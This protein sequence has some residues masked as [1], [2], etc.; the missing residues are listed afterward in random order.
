MEEK[1]MR[2]EKEPW[3]TKV[4]FNTVAALFL[5]VFSVVA[6]LLI[7]Y[8]IEKPRMLFGRS[9]MNLEPSL[10]PRLSIAGLFFLSL[11][12]LTHSFQIAEKNL[13]KEMGKAGVIRVGVTFLV[14]LGYALLFEPLG[15][16]LS[17]ALMVLILTIYFGNRN[18]L[19]I[20][21]VTAAA[22]LIV[23]Y[24]FTKTLQVSLPEIPFF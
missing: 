16:V 20:V 22:P 6:Y 4:N 11:W 15:F 13:F 12:Y 5:L 24:L 7:P 2:A 14:C 23:Y 3:R 18:I 9:L 10:F 1:T 8:Q 21:A 17:S 19:L